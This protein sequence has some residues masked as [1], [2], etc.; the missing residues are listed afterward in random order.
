MFSA[1]AKKIQSH[2][3]RS[4]FFVKDHSTD[5]EVIPLMIVYV[6]FEVEDMSKL[7]GMIKALLKFLG[8]VIK[9]ED[10]NALGKEIEIV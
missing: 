1:Y 7:C 10:G 5:F 8:R 6:S 9:S 4:V 3:E 2:L